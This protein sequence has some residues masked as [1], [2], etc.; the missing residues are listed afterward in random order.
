MV[1]NQYLFTTIKI[2]YHQL[3]FVKKIGMGIGSVYFFTF[4]YFSDSL[5]PKIRHKRYIQIL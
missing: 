4:G 1:L 2:W 3:G 5:K